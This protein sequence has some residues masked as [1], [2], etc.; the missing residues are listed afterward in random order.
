LKV[1]KIPDLPGEGINGIPL[2]FLAKPAFPKYV[3]PKKLL[4]FSGMEK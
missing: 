2:L 3:Y 1:I 4:S